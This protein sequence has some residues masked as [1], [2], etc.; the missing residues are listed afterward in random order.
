MDTQENHPLS[1][2]PESDAWSVASGW[3][4]LGLLNVLCVNILQTPSSGLWGIRFS[5]HAV[6][7]GRH[8]AFALF[9]A[10]LSWIAARFLSSSRPRRLVAWAL[11]WALAIAVGAQLLPEDVEGMALRYAERIPL[12][13]AVIRAALVMLFASGAPLSVWAFKVLSKPFVNRLIAAV[14]GLSL[15][16]VNNSFSPLDNT[17]IH[18]FMSVATAL[19][20]AAAFAGIARD[21]ARK[22][23]ALRSPVRSAIWLSFVAWGT[24]AIAYPHE[25]AV[26]V[27]ASHWPSALLVEE[28][29]WSHDKAR[30]SRAP[31]LNPYFRNRKD[32]API[33]PSHALNL[34]QDAIV[35][36]ISVDGMRADVLSNPKERAFVPVIDKLAKGGAEFTEARAT[37]SQTVVSLSGLSTSSY[38]SQQ[39]WTRKS[40]TA[41]LWPWNDQRPHLAQ[42]LTTAKVRTVSIPTATWLTD[43]W[44]ILRGFTENRFP[45]NQK[46]WVKGRAATASILGALS[47]H[48]EGP[49]FLFVHYLDSHAPYKAGGGGGGDKERYLRALKF[50]DSEIGRVLAA[51]KKLGMKDRLTVILT[52]DHGEAFGE[53]GTRFHATTVYDELLRVPLIIHGPGV[54]PRKIATKVSL[55]DIA[56]T[57]LDMFQLDTP[58]EYM[59][60]SLTPLLVGK[61][62]TFS[63]PIAADSRLK[64]AMVFPGGWKV[65]HNQRLNAT[66]IYDLERDQR[67][68]KNLYPLPELEDE[69]IL[70]HAFFEQHRLRDNGYVP[71]YRK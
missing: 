45:K 56:P 46:G 71:P 63:R 57:V 48:R 18:F 4:A 47:T 22:A 29:A 69:V 64:R 44:G 15:Y 65:I 13:P 12:S 49:L 52:S 43:E 16:V 25:S 1:S 39:E 58:G 5:Q 10:L 14:F 30:T 54:V 8:V 35:L 32:Q 38:F 41:E 62:V 68:L 34:A 60:Q 28:L 23:E 20:F 33:P 31:L 2:A 37:G 9:A 70:L 21:V 42:L 59:G 11:C 19:L 40:P 6:D 3:L 27:E 17:G 55:V 7:F 50:V 67:E 61:Q 66:E 51:A 36:L 26:L 53:H 24:W